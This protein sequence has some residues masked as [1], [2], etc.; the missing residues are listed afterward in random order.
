MIAV[1]SIGF[2]ATASAAHPAA[3]KL[4]SHGIVAAASTTPAAA[5]PR[6]VPLAASKYVYVAKTG[7]KYHKTSCRYV[8]KSKKKVT[9]KW[10]KA[11]GYKACKVC[12]PG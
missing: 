2:V 8:K 4:V 11:H 10:A 9:L 6:Y 12:N 5:T 1:L 7:T 3:A